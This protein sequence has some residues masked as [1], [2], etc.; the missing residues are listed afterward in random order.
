NVHQLFVTHFIR[1]PVEFLVGCLSGRACS[2]VLDVLHEFEEGALGSDVALRSACDLAA[3]DG[4]QSWHFGDRVALADGHETM[5]F[6][7]DER[8]DAL[9]FAMPSF[10]SRI[11]GLSF[12]ETAVDRRSAIADAL[13]VQHGCLLFLCAHRSPSSAAARGAARSF[14][15]SSK[16]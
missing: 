15:I 2:G 8:L 3:D 4:L 16:L 7:P 9:S 10:S 13:A 1:V 11:A 5:D 14:A 12:A 6:L